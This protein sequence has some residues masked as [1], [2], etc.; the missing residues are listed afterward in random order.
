VRR[1]RPTLEFLEDRLAP[2]PLQG[3]PS[4]AGELGPAAGAVT[5][6]ADAGL[7]LPT[8]AIGSTSP[9]VGTG[10][11]AALDSLFAAGFL[12]VDGFGNT[13]TTV[14]NVSTVYHTGSQQVL[15]QAIVTAQDGSPITDGL[16]T[17]TI[18][19][20]GG[21]LTATAMP[22]PSRPGLF[23]TMVT[24]PPGTP[25]GQYTITADD[26]GSI[27]HKLGGSSGT[28]TLTV[29]AAAT[30]VAVPAVSATF[31]NANSQTV[32]LS[33]N[34]TS[35]AGTVNEGAVA[36]SVVNP[37]GSNLT[38]TANVVNGVASGTITLPIGFLGGAYTI[39]AAYTDIPNADGQVNFAAGSNSG[40]LTVNG[41]DTSTAVTNVSTS[42]NSAS[43]NITLTA[44]VTAS[45]GST[46]NE[47]N[48]T[49]SIGSLP[50]VTVAVNSAGVATSS[51]TLPA[52][53]ASGSYTIT[54]DYADVTNANKAVNFNANSGTGTLNVTTA[55]TGTNKVMVNNP[56]PT[57]TTKTPVN[58][59][60]Q[61]VTLSAT[62]TTEAN[63]PLPLPPSQPALETPAIP[64]PLPDPLPLAPP[65]AFAPTTN[66]AVAV[67]PLAALRGPEPGGTSGAGSAPLTSIP[68]F[69]PEAPILHVPFSAMRL[70]SSAVPPTGAEGKVP[71]LERVQM[72]ALRLGSSLTEGDDSVTLIEKIAGPT[73]PA[74]SPAPPP[75]GPAAPAPPGPP[76]DKPET[77]PRSALPLRLAPWAL[78]AAMLGL[79]VQPGA[80]P[81]ERRKDLRP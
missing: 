52:S 59:S 70:P 8:P 35:P 15:L 56:S 7:P 42:F 10:S 18:V 45:N 74:P 17:F 77:Q 19:T 65:G 55:D 36:F 40:T 23:F 57:T 26:S 64:A 76:A 66:V 80:R 32:T 16:V 47:G 13:I 67:S 4:S 79:V 78:L 46:V 28:G 60:T 29:G 43:Q 9:A 53:F 75:K 68:V 72:K 39:N 44:T 37:N 22:N 27:Q 33:A 6:T 24:L 81:D 25:V 2:A 41:A 12:P 49:F 30:T 69:D 38:V 48:V 50:M 61:N 71:T 34:V 20:P 1:Y 54:A 3:L 51:F 14:S 58:S 11:I 5:Q 31:N 21:P 62:I 73:P 63:A